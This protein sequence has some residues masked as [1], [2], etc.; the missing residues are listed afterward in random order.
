MQCFSRIRAAIASRLCRARSVLRSGE[1]PGCVARYN[2]LSRLPRFGIAKTRAGLG[3]QFS[4][5]WRYHARE[6]REE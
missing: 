5:I 1:A 3:D 4:S 2:R 6:Y